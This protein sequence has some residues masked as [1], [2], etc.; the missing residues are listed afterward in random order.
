M[1]PLWLPNGGLSPTWLSL[2]R[3]RLALR[4]M[5]SWHA[6]PCRFS[7]TSCHPQQGVLAFRRCQ[8][9]YV[10]G[11]S[12]TARGSDLAYRAVLPM[13]LGAFLSKLQPADLQAHIDAELESYSSLRQSRL[14]SSEYSQTAPRRS[15]LDAWL[16][17]R[18]GGQFIRRS[19]G[20]SS[21]RQ[22]QSPASEPA[23]LPDAPPTPSSPA[24]SMLK[25]YLLWPTASPINVDVALITPPPSLINLSG[26][27]LLNNVRL[28]PGRTYY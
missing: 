9:Q 4:R 28:N 6:V 2:V 19:A 24:Y 21:P 10:N 20:P 15:A 25:V 12:S 17:S 7:W 3:T 5:S 22:R 11:S 23:A 1:K 13:W 8:W 14:L 16:Q 26:Q 18:V 27:G